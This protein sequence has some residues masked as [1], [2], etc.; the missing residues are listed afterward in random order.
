MKL[1]KGRIES[2]SRALVDRLTRG[3]YVYIKIDS[4]EMIDILERIVI[5]ELMVESHLNE[6]VRQI[7]RAHE[8]EIDK[9]DLDYRKMFQMTKK[10]LAKE[11]GIIL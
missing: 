11:R 10:Q 9:G 6:E 2:L 5:D 8:S 4:K 3:Q 1:S 7:L